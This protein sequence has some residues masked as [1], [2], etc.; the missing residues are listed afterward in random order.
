M[1]KRISLVLFLLLT[2]IMVFTFVACN[3]QTNK[4]LPDD[5]GGSGDN[6]SGSSSSQTM[7]LKFEFPIAPS[8][9]FSSIFVEE[10]ELGTYVKCYVVYS[11]AKSGATLREEPIGG[12]QESMVD[13]ADRAKLKTVGH[14]NIH[15]T[16][17]HNGKEL[18]GS[19]DLHL[20]D[21]SGAVSL[22]S[23][24]F[25]L[26]DN[27]DSGKVATA[28]FG[29]TAGTSASVNVEKG[30]VIQSWNEFVNAFQMSMNGKALSEVVDGD[31]NTLSAE[32]D[33]FP[34][35]ISGDTT[36]TTKWTDNVVFV[37]YDLNFPKEADVQT[38]AV[39]PR[40]YFEEGGEF[41]GKLSVERRIGFALQP[42]REKLDVL[43]G[44]YFAGW[45]NSENDTL[46]DFNAYIGLNDVNLKARW[47]A[48]SYSFTL[49]TM[50]G[51]FFPN[52]T[53]SVDD[54]GQTITLDNAKELGYT[55]IESTSR[56]GF[57]D[58]KLNRV[59]F[60][61]FNYGLNYDD[62]VAEVTISSTGKKVVLKFSD[63][64]KP[65]KDA[66]VF[67]KGDSTS[68]YLM[69]D[70]YLYSDYQCV[71]RL[72]TENKV[73][74]EQPV[75]YLRWH[76]DAPENDKDEYLRRISDWYT[77]LLFKDGISVKADG[78]LRIDKINDYSVHELI[79]PATLIFGGKERAVTEIG[80]N[81]C[82][83]SNAL[84]KI[85]M[86]GATN[87]TTIG[88]SAFAHDTK[89]TDVIFPS[90]GNNNITEVGSNAFADT[91]YERDFTY[92]SHGAQF[93][94]INKMI[95]K[96][97]GG[98]T[99]VIDLSDPENYYVM[100]NSPFMTPDERAAFNAQLAVVDTIVSG[101]F[102]DCTSLVE[103]SLPVGIKE[104]KND[105]FSG[106]SDFVILNVPNGSKLTSVG[107]S[108]FDGSGIMTTPAESNL[109]NPTYDAILIGNIYYRQL[110]TSANAVTVP[111]KYTVGTGEE[112]VDF[113]INYI[114]ANAFE[115]CRA[116]SEINFEKVD[117][118]LGIGKD[119]FLDTKFI[120]EQKDAFTVVNGIMS[121]YFTTNATGAD[122]VV[123]SNVEVISTNA[124]NTYARYFATLQINSSVKLIEDY[125]FIGAHSLRSV[126]FTD[127]VVG[128]GKLEGAPSID[129]NTFAN[130]SGKMFSATL[131]FNVN[132][133]DYFAELA[134]GAKSTEDEITLKWLNLY[135]MY[136]DSFQDEGIS[137]VEVDSNVISNVLLKINTGK[138]DNAFT[139]KYG[140]NLIENALKITRKTGVNSTASLGWE[141]NDMSFVHVK[142]NE[143]ALKFKYNG[144]D[145]VCEDYIIT[146]YNAIEKSSNADKNLK[147]YSSTI[148]SEE[149][150]QSKVVSANGLLKS[151]SKYWFEGIGG[152][153]LNQRYP[154]FYTSY[155][156]EQ[157]KFVYI[158]VEGN[159]QSINVDTPNDFNTRQVGSAKETT[160]TVNFHGVGT[161]RF[162]LTYT[163]VLAKYVEMM[164][165][166]AIVI[167]VNGTAESYLRDHTVRLI[168]QDNLF[169]DRM[170][171]ADRFTF[172]SVDDVA[173]DSVSDVVTSVLGMHKLEIQYSQSDSNGI[174]KLVL[175]YTV[176]SEADSNSFEYAIVNDRQRTARITRWKGDANPITVVVPD[177]CIIDG[178]EYTIVR[179]GDI[180]GNVT[181]T[182]RGVFENFRTLTAVYLPE[183]I[184]SI[185]VNTF[186][187]CTLLSGV[188]TASKT[189]AE[190]ID[191]PGIEYNA[192]NGT[193]YFEA[194]GRE[195]TE[196]IDG[197]EWR[198]QPAVLKSLAIDGLVLGDTLV[199]G[200]D[201]VSSTESN[202]K[203]RI[204]GLANGVKIDAES[205]AID[206]YL[207]DTIYQRVNIVDK[208]GVSITPIFVSSESEYLFK[209]IDRVP[210]KLAIISTGAF[211]NCISLR[212]LDFSGATELTRIGTM[213]FAGSG[214]VSIDFSK[215]T[216]LTQIESQTFQ[217]SNKLESIKLP[218][219]INAIGESA[220]D[221]CEL[222]ASVTGYDVYLKTIS[223][224]A[225]NRCLSL[226]R[227]ELFSGITSIGTDAF[228][229]CGALTVY[230]HV[231]KA[232]AAGWGSSWASSCP[233]I[234]NCD[235]NDATEDGFVY[236]II[237]GIRYKLNVA[238]QTATV[239]GQPYSASGDIVILASVTYTVQVDGALVSRQFTVTTIGAYAFSGNT[240]IT[241]VTVTSSLT[242][243][244]E[245]AFD[246]CSSLSSFTFDG[247][248]RLEV[249]SFSAFEGCTALEDV[250]RPQ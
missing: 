82:S 199:I 134:S 186:A 94:V 171:T 70:D 132:V 228:A 28:Y 78:S 188:Y 234:W 236:A 231:T 39:D 73:S 52:L 162:K 179:I 212:H 53:S 71:T 195:F 65:S 176:V 54:K 226:T 147:F 76:F 106:L 169:D 152:Q 182:A 103:F 8:S 246:G 165:T 250:P 215:N 29:T 242:T 208:N 99:D 123:P 7:S 205:G 38:G 177:T 141:E 112:A 217:N 34:Y 1:K 183:T 72:E 55:V 229:S 204:I 126:I 153:V 90:E 164:Q 40:T 155:A 127:V 168:K 206:V 194:V 200:S 129:V 146:V 151:N 136:P 68:P 51:E 81:S 139:D 67:F 98:D 49:Y 115:G 102:A 156:G 128:D 198:I 114:A 86:S 232:A 192:E 143:Y 245:H 124:F 32:S 209:T 59:T 96:Y 178:K 18:K 249:V 238:E 142:G 154:T 4:G 10:F 158:D 243:I 41:Y 110:N 113:E 88:A 92:A 227:F 150:S 220:F 43:N 161:Y 163:V 19:F 6:G 210:D 60:T 22:V 196:I 79:I 148:Y 224:K 93:I 166:E 225:F 159:E 133:I 27:G 66:N 46:F 160:L 31:G 12:V 30:A 97:V 174:L 62:Y 122:V 125:A 89:L 57:S 241:S 33:K 21:K 63:I 157:I 69:L 187:G 26:R 138:D 216:K 197:V 172:V 75:A 44:Y 190:E 117:N 23:Y 77:K 214:L 222:L 119:A 130:S 144:D 202:L 56:F 109:Y 167:P 185:G 120:E 175:Y 85:D 100:G 137:K 64:Y 240:K 11:D 189:D 145:T 45:F 104:I 15:V 36:F 107:E 218:V 237:N 170:I 211:K 135:T 111:E 193:G 201:Y 207:P 118:I 116:L 244:E 5:L 42:E 91:K 235:R 213:A 20:K 173:I 58:G 17:E 74:T 180:T 181:E 230:S 35:T 233:I 108:A 131:F 87:L 80:Y 48:A 219:Y 2:V 105:A 84:T 47:V 83:S 221:G 3:Q 140:K 95:Y 239:A 223:A 191:I 13:E 184:E 16:V 9:I 121:A 248:N 14:H 101:A 61:G 50:G 25:D 247:G 203:F 24:T 149:V 37:T